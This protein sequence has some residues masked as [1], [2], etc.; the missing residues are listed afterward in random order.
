[1]LSCASFVCHVCLEVAALKAENRRRSKFHNKFSSCAFCKFSA[2]HLRLH[3]TEKF[4]DTQAFETEERLRF[5]H[6]QMY[7]DL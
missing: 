6:M 2:T 5:P 7:A 4:C 1:M 3:S